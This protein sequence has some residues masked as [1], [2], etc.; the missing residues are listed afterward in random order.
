[1]LE[2]RR[3]QRHRQQQRQHTFYNLSSDRPPDVNCTIRFDHILSTPS[4]SDP[5]ACSDVTSCRTPHDAPCILLNEASHNEH[6]CLGEARTEP[7]QIAR[8]PATS[9]TQKSNVILPLCTTQAG[10]SLRTKSESQRRVTASSFPARSL[11]ASG[12]RLSSHDLPYPALPRITRR[13][14]KTYHPFT[15]H[16]PSTGLALYASHFG[17]VGSLEDKDYPFCVLIGLILFP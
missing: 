15:S 17:H 12:T 9:S 4:N 7:R 8:A 16:P 6:G 1:M 5:S 14:D 11:E 10:L 2:W 3:R 13:Q